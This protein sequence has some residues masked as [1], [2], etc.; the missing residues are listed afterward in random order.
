ME[1]LTLSF[2]EFDAATV[3][4]YGNPIGRRYIIGFTNVY[5]TLWIATCFAGVENF[6]YL[7][8]LS[9]D[10]AKAQNRLF[11]IM[12]TTD[13]EVD[14]DL[15]GDNGY[16]FFKPLA[17]HRYEPTLLSFSRFAG[18]DMRTI[19]PNETYLYSRG[20]Y[21]REPEYKKMSGLLWATYLNKEEKT[22]RGLRRRVI[23][24]QCLI[25]AGIL[26]KVGKEYLTP[27]QIKQREI[28]KGHHFNDNERITIS[29]KK[30]GKTSSFETVYGTTFIS[31]YVD[32]NNRIFKYMGSNP[33]DISSEVFINVKATI[34]HDIYKGNPETKLQR[35]KII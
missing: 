28:I 26:I 25:D 35:I 24:R 12:G 20:T 6:L 19:D 8:N 4:R 18:K 7:Q 32:E 33:P 13:F 27:A 29:L 30:F 15:K 10:F 31:S 9:I 11:E 2:P 21:D 17:V 16:N 22:F 34:K 23:A 3:N 5:Y 1:T 14:L